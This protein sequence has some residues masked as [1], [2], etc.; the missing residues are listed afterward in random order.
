MIITLIILT[1][2][3]ATMHKVLMNA[4]EDYS[5]DNTVDRYEDRVGKMY[6]DIIRKKTL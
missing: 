5:Y 4:V 2:A 6:W 3:A 1:V